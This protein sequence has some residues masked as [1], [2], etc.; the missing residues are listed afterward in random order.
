[1]CPCIKPCSPYRR[2]AEAKLL[3]LWGKQLEL[4][5]RQVQFNGQA[6]EL[7]SVLTTFSSLLLRCGE[8]KASEGLLGVLGLGKKSP[9]SHRSV[10][11]P[12]ATL[13]KLTIDRDLLQKF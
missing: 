10:K 1:M 9:Y 6:G 11:I 7:V 12:Q 2:A 5:Q 3:L 13:A 4:V 8:D